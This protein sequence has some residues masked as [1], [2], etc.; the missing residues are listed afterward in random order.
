METNPIFVRIGGHCNAYPED[1]LSLK[2][3]INYTILSFTNGDTKIVATTLKILEERL[4]PFG[5]YRTH[6]NSIVNMKFVKKL[7][8]KKDKLFVKLTNA[9]Q[10]LV[11]R[12][13]EAG[14]F[15]LTNELQTAI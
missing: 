4:L 10:L 15:E 9:D 14:L 8:R 6:K 3:D 5:F 11:S 12:R 13:R 1:I 2:G 7:I